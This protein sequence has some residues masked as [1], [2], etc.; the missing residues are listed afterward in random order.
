MKDAPKRSATTKGN[1]QSLHSHLR[2]SGDFADDVNIFTWG[3]VNQADLVTV[4]SLIT[5]G[6]SGIT[7][8]RTSDGG[9][10][11]LAILTTGESPDKYYFTHADQFAAFAARVQDWYTARL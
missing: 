4:I 10:L 7:L 6:G 5:D 9:A 1:Q 11:S 3:G 2:G 8:G